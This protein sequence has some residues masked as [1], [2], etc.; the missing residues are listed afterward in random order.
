MSEAP[1]AEKAGPPGHNGARPAHRHEQG[2]GRGRSHAGAT[3]TALGTA[4]ELAAG[5]RQRPK[6]AH[7]CDGTCGQMPG[8]CP[9]RVNTR[10]AAGG[11][12]SKA[13]RRMIGLP[14]QLVALLRA[15]QAEQERE[16]ATGRQLWHDEG[17]VFASPAGKPLIPNTDYHAWKRLLKDAGLRES[18]LHDARH[19][20]ATVLLILG[21][22]VRTVMS[23]MGWSSAEMAARY[24]H[25]TDAIRQDV[26]R[27]VDGLIWQ[28]PGAA[29]DAAIVTVSRG[30]LV[31]I[32]RLAELG[33]AHGDSTAVAGSR[34]AIEHI[35]AVLVGSQRPGTGSGPTSMGE[36]K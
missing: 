12:K 13:G 31:A 6:Y 10:L 34:D 15:H 3:G 19:T 14:P 29:T 30:S 17:W 28:A 16:Q 5:S 24:Q 23:I 22:P 8:Y 7:G 21:V 26:A 25:V 35:R 32:L 9:Q 4:H 20:A 36:T 33:L 11:V 27:Q 1:V 18:R 2:S